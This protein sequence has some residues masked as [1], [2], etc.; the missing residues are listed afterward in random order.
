MVGEEL[1]SADVQ[2]MQLTCHRA[3]PPTV[4]N[5]I[6]KRATD[7]SCLHEWHLQPYVL[8]AMGVSKAEPE[9][10][11]RDGTFDKLNKFYL[12][13][14]HIIYPCVISIE[15]SWQRLVLA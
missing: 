6:S 8:E 2:Q 14:G 9:E 4:P 1:S 3:R 13:S 5:V 12:H 11:S 15:R 7:P 10:T